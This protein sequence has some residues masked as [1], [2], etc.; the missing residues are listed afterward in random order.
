M[1]SASNEMTWE[2]KIRNLSATGRAGTEAADG[3]GTRDVPPGYATRRR[4]V[5]PLPPGPADLAILDSSP[6]LLG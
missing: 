4:A 5:S 6:W 3:G 1:L 2:K